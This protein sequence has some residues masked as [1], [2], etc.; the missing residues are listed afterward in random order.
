VGLP[1]FP[2]ESVT[3]STNARS[4][5]FDFRKNPFTLVYDGCSHEE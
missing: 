4:V 2:P 3:M 1:P 5:V